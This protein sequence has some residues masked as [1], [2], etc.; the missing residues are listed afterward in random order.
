MSHTPG[1]GR[2]RPGQPTRVRPISLSFACASTRAPRHT[3][4]SELAQEA[5]RVGWLRTEWGTG[6]AD[7]SRPVGGEGGGDGVVIET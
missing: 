5:S 4:S 1:D 2:P 6:L 7:I 3:G